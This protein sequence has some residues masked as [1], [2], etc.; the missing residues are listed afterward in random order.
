[1]MARCRAYRFCVT[2]LLLLAG[3]AIAA[4]VCLDALLEPIREANGLPALAAAVVK[5]GQTVAVGAV[6]VRKAGSSERVTADDKWHIGSCT[7]S[8]TAALAAM[9]VE[10]GAMRWD[11][12]L[13][14]M[15]PDLESQMQPGWRD[16]TLEQLLAHRGGA[17]HELNEQELWGRLWQ[18]ADQPPREQRRYLRR[19]LLTKHEPVSPPGTKTVYS[20]AGYALVG[21]ALEEILDRPWEDLLRDRLFVPLGMTGA[22]FGAPASVGA[23][24][25]PWG[26]KAGDDGAFEPV[27]PGLHADNPAAIGPGGTVHCRLADLAQYA[28]WHLAG[29]RGE[30]TL[31]HPE[32]FERLHTPLAADSEYAL[33]WI[34]TER[35]WGGGTVL[36]HAGSNTM[37]YAVIWIAPKKDFAAVV[38]TNAGGAVAEKA[39]DTAAAAL[40]REYLS[41]N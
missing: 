17:P 35:P 11:A 28:A 16:V 2:I 34:A 22:G 33:G 14:E 38:C 32:T 24:D 10:D 13:A 29:A 12:T 5:G 36:T 3:R 25:Q 6:G 20:N 1:M 39:T 18:R 21:H 41:P 4:P 27:A 40:I 26:H 31:L 9:L 30:G 15:F 23:V 37:F 8:M 7:K 19:E